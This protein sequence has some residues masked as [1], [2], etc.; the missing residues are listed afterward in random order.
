DFAVPVATFRAAHPDDLLA[1]V[2]A[3]PVRGRVG[4][5]L[6]FD[7]DRLVGLVS[8][9]ALAPGPEVSRAAP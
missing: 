3:R 2:A 4:H 5:T 1:D 6:V 7:G 9:E 8:P